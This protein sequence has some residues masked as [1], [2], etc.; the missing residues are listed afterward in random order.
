MG[1]SLWTEL[2]SLLLCTMLFVCSRIVG[3]LCYN[4]LSFLKCMG[5]SLHITQRASGS[6]QK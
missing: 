6:V 2:E 5:S 4:R 3:C 1:R